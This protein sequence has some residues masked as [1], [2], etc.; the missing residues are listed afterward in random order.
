MC[1]RMRKGGLG[2]DFGEKGGWDG[3]ARVCDC[4]AGMEWGLLCGYLNSAL[5]LGIFLIVGFV[6]G[7]F[8]DGR[9]LIG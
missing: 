4:C 5:D 1:S 9:D 8:L 7:S 6:R 3:W 2:L